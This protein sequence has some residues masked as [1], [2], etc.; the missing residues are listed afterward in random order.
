MCPTADTTKCCTTCCLLPATP[1]LFTS[2]VSSVAALWGNQY[3]FVLNII[4]FLPCSAGLSK[5]EWLG[6]SSQSLTQRELLLSQKDR[7]TLMGMSFVDSS[8]YHLT[9]PHVYALFIPTYHKQEGY[10]NLVTSQD[11]Y[12]RQKEACVAL[13]STPIL[14]KSLS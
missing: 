11:V 9:G 2:K 7:D 10:F 14:D 13:Q 3:V 4:Y 6:S 1:A 8:Y 5:Q 12:D